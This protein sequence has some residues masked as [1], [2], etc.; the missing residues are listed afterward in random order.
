MTLGVPQVA[1][2]VAVARHDDHKR[3]H[4][5][6]PICLGETVRLSPRVNVAEVVPVFVEVE[7]AVPHLR[8]AWW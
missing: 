2:R 1:F 3:R 7:V 4:S 6:A 5:S 8:P